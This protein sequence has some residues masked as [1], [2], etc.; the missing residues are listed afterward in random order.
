MKL[1][2]AF[3]G[4]GEFEKAHA[5]VAGLGLPCEVVSPDPGCALV[6]A[7]ALACTA[8]GL[9]AIQNA[10]GILCAGW[11]TRRLPATALPN[12]PPPQFA[13]DVFRH[14]AVMFFGPC[15]ADETRI[16]LIAH[17]GGDLREVLPYLNSTMPQACFNVGPCTLTF[18]DG[19]R[20]VTLYPQRVTI[21]KA[22]D[23]IDGWRTLEKIRV[24]VNQT[25]A[26]R[27]ALTPSYAR[28]S[29]PPALEIYKRLPRTNCGAC[30]EK[31]CM[32]FAVSLWQGTGTPSRCTPLFSGERPELEAAFLDICRGLGAPETG[33]MSPI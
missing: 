2:A 11:T 3:S 19:A 1:I 32:A 33:E 16:R 25:W 24:M 10:T 21:G 26:R 8:E 23:L 4:R 13:E 20:L 14:A 22:D 7:P 17:L 30:G 6:G 27:A 31:T 18:M 15:M 12:Q 28:R 29:R 5:L 9:S